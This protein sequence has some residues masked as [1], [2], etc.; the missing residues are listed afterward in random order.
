MEALQS[1]VQLTGGGYAGG[2]EAK[3]HEEE[4]VT[5]DRLEWSEPIRSGMLLFREKP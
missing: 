1:F 3:P 2:G 4:V 5:E